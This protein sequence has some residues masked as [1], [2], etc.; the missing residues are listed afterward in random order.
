MRALIVVGCLVGLL[1]WSAPDATALSRRKECRLACGVAIDACVAQ[2]GKRRRCKRQTLRRCRQEGVATCGVT[3]TTTTPGGT[4][5]TLAS[6]HGCTI[7]AATDLRAD[8]TPTVTFTSFQYTPKCA[9]I[10][11]GQSITFE[12]D[13]A[14]HPLVGGTVS[15]GTQTRDFAS[16]IGKTSSGSSHAVVFPSAGTF[17]YYCDNHGAGFGMVGAVFVDP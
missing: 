2:G 13:F 16:P 11:A 17:P 7:G 15:G 10:A 4:T 1:D 8:A 12:G 5:T 6:I 9:R 3:T 14:F